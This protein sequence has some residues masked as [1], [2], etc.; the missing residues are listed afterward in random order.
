MS[1]KDYKNCNV[2]A[3]RGVCVRWKSLKVWLRDANERI[4]PLNLIQLAVDKITAGQ[5]KASDCPKY[6][7]V[8]LRNC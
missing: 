6:E 3:K 5:K 7:R 4:E 2:C 1:T 8:S